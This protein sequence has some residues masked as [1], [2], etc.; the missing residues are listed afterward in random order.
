L[1]CTR[2]VCR[3]HV[4]GRHDAGR[5]APPTLQRPPGSCHPRSTHTAVPRRQRVLRVVYGAPSCLQT[6]VTAPA[7]RCRCLAASSHARVSWRV[8]CCVAGSIR[9][10]PVM[11]AACAAAGG[12]VLAPVWA[13]SSTCRRSL[14][15][16]RAIMRRWRQ[17]PAHGAAAV[18]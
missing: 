2:L 8:H 16:H 1:E 3:H 18:R 9:H 6:M 5:S 4:R 11:Y 13:C 15:P 7:C 14:T 12:V 10:R 17:Q